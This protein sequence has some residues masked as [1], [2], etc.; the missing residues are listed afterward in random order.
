MDENEQIDLDL[1]LKCQ[2]GNGSGLG[3]AFGRDGQF[4]GQLYDR[5]FKKIYGFIY[6][7]ACHKQT[8]ED[9]TS[10]VFYKALENI[11]RFDASRGKFSAWLFQIARNC[12]IDYYRTKHNTEDIES[13]WDLETGKSLE[14]DTDTAL[15]MEQLGRLLKDV[16]QQQREIVLMRLWDGLSYREIAEILQL[17]ESNC[18]MTF[19]RALEKLQTQLILSLLFMLI[20]KIY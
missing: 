10:R 12:L 2:S 15:A 5:Y 13:I 4:F 6:S 8:A 7:R 17:G 16:N 14:T 18:K 1:D 9:L 20:V 3:E 19:S 11:S